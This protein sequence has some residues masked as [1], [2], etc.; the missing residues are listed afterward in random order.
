MNKHY[1]ILILIGLIFLVT[2]L[3]QISEIPVSLYWDEASIGYNAFSVGKDLKDEWGEFLPI[4]F[5]A[6]GEFKL[7]VYIYSSAIFVKIFGL[8]ELA[9]RL[10][11]VLFSLGTLLIIYFLILEISKKK[12]AALA[13]GFL[14]TISPWFFIF[15]RTGY[16]ATAGVMF[17][18]LGTYINIKYK[19]GWIL[20]LG[21]LSFILSIYSYNSFRILAPITLF[22]FIGINTWQSKFNKKNILLSLFFISLFAVSLI[23]VI[24]LFIYD[25]GFG[26]AQ[27]FSLIPS[28]QQV[29]DLS[30]KP[31]LQII[32]DRSGSTN[33]GTNFL[34]VI[35]NYFSHLSFNFL[36]LG[37]PNPRSQNPGVGQ[38]YYLDLI[39]FAL[40]LLYIKI[41]KNKKALILIFLMFLSILPGSLFKEAPH[42]L[43][44]LSFVPFFCIINAFGFQFLYEKHK[45]IAILIC[46]AYFILFC[47][48]FYNF[49]TLYNFNTSKDWQL[50]YKQLFVNYKNE[51][52]EFDKV[53]I[54]DDLAQPYIFALYYL[55]YDPQSFRK[56]VKYNSIDRWGQS[57]AAQIGNLE[58]RKPLEE[59]FSKQRVLI[60]SE[61]QLD[62]ASDQIKGINN[63][64]LIWVYR[65]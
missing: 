54:T 16:E 4:H 33:W 37:D 31:Q 21:L 26:R 34:T 58:F 19:N 28:V 15:S 61:Y 27:A 35:N 48:Y 10:P 25:A 50:A 46:G 8:S 6:F 47:N 42:A 24:R 13:G 65:K 5:R 7:P 64:P 59:D 12:I 1:L 40:G 56:E 63:Q 36:F 9:V 3:Y 51:F 32:F 38:I 29:Y 43:R 30:G 17:Y 11:A 14:F 23:P 22:L 53:I 41:T 39:L 44:T 52:K 2:R 62:G 57:A 45:K 60:F 20:F 55:K 18:L 49:I